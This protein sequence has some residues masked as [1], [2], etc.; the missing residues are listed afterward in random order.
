ME[1]LRYGYQLPGA[2]AADIA[3][4]EAKL[5]VALPS[6]IRS[7]LK[8]SNGFNEQIGKG[9]LIL[10][11]V[12]EL[13]DADGYGIFDFTNDRILIRSNGGPTVYGVLNGDYISIPFVFAGDWQHEVLTLGRTFNEFIKAI[14]NGEGW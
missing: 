11:S 14:E 1:K 13:A 7:F 3:R 4:C 5:N 8:I 6:E 10:W 12:G 9:Y 2:R